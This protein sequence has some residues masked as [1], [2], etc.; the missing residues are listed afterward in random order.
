M[1]SALEKGKFYVGHTSNIYRRIC[2]HFYG[3]GAVYTR[4]FKPIRCLSCVEGGLAL[5]KAVFAGLVA[6][7]GWENVR[8][9]GYTK[10]QMREP[11][12]YLQAKDYS[13][14]KASKE[15]GSLSGEEG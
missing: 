3:T 2:Q 15:E 7:K 4:E 10:A 6:Q 5:E 13:A 11:E 9:A 8:G 1:P 12:W 14:W